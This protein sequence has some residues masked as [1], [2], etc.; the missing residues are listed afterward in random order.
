MN[1][2]CPACRIP[3]MTSRSGFK[4]PSCLVSAP[5]CLGRRLDFSGFFPASSDP[6]RERV[7]LTY[8]FYALA[9]APLALL[10]MLAV[11]KSSLGKLVTHYHQAL[12]SASH[13]VLDVA[14]G[15][16]SL[17]RVAARRL[18]LPHPLIGLDFSGEMLSQAE[19]NLGHLPDFRTVQADAC[20]LPYP[21][22]EFLTVCCFGGLHVIAHPERAMS[23]MA[24]VLAPGGAFHASIL[25]IPHGRISEY[26][27]HRYVELG[28]LSTRFTRSK[29]ENLVSQ[30]GL[31][32]TRSSLNG[33]M[34]LVSARRR[35]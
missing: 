30:T 17:T 25:L 3:L 11:W 28:F 12:Q 1:L 14:I 15:D 31:Q 7:S 34:L 10:N 33:R 22:G 13:P 23:E 19:A 18:S 21:D 2:Q 27:S 9:Y 24:R 6:G 29:A 35:V 4:C 5:L 32:I 16:G 20:H 8:R 26:L